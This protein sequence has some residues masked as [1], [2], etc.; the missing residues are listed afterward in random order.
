M[1]RKPR[2]EFPAAFY[3]VISRGNQRQAI[4]H[5]SSDYLTYTEQLKH[6]KTR[7]DVT[8]YSY[9]LMPNHLHLLVE[10]NEAPPSKFMQGLQF[11]YTRY[12]NQ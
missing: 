1:A 2:I 4:F 3:H 11:T 5:E 6:Y 9:V 10:T 7:Y 8:I 12:Y